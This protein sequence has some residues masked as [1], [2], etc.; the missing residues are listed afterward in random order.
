MYFF[1]PHFEWWPYVVAYH[2]LEIAGICFALRAVMTSRTPQAAIGWGL[3]LV[4]FPLFALPLYWVF[5]ETRFQGYVTAESGESSALTHAV[6]VLKDAMQ[7]HAANFTDKYFDVQRLSQEISGVTATRDND[8]RLLVD[9]EE[10]FAAMFHDIAEAR[11]TL[12]VHFYI[13]NDDTLGRRLHDAILNA[14]RRGV[15]C[16]VLYDH[17]GSKRIGKTWTP[18]LAAEG[19]AVHDFRSNRK[20]GRHF[21]VNFRNHRKLVVVDGRV[22]YIGGFN[23]GDEYLGKGPLGVW[24]DTHV[25]VEGAAVAGLLIP[26]IEDWHYVTGEVAQVPLRLTA[27]GKNAAL[28]F[29][30]GPAQP[31][32][33]APAVY[34]EVLHSAKERIWIASPY[35]VPDIATRT[36][37]AH[38]AL[39]G[40]DVR[41]LLPGVADHTLPWLSSFTFYPQMQEARVRMWRYKAGFMHQKVLLCD[42]DLAIV[43]TVNLDHRS[44]MIN[45]ESALVVENN[46]FAA[47]V[48]QM[49]ER[50][51]ALADEEDLNRFEKAP[52]FFRLKCRL[53]SLTSPEQ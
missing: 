20:Y 21:Q 3:A 34:M 32:T 46:A 49:L 11:E 35:F 8:I 37:L 17:V 4:V 31:W 45:F 15:A 38:A 40:V 12:V 29:A 43:G 30:S 16:R 19:V 25:R 47:E 48:E 13:I 18:S 53:A 26:F 33:M 10:T 28:P 1:R 23:A 22:A 41:I 9:G 42:N 7:P 14:A 39:R 50:D 2:L 27:S 44:F 52:F 6:Q 36:A 5:G 24:R 51:F